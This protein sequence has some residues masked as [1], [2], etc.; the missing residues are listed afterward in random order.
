MNLLIVLVSVLALGGAVVSLIYAI[1]P[2]FI[3][4]LIVSLIALFLLMASKL[5]F[6]LFQ[7]DGESP[8]IY[9]RSKGKTYHIVRDCPE[10]D[11]ANTVRVPFSYAHRNRMK[12]CPVCSGIFDEPAQEY[13]VQAEQETKEETQ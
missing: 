11:G 5:G 1:T 12:P 3:I 13:S 2:L 4:C 6:T 7:S 10:L 9:I 8:F